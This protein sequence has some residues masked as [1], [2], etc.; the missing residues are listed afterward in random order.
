[1]KDGYLVTSE[2]QHAHP[3]LP[4]Y[5][6]LPGDLLVKTGIQTYAKDAPGLAVEGFILDPEEEATL[7]LVRFTCTGLDYTIEDPA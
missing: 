6:L 1:M 3:R 5:Q 2:I 7:K 4:A